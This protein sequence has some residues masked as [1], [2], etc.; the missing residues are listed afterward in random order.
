ML[1]PAE[2]GCIFTSSLGAFRRIIAYL[3]FA[4][5]ATG[6]F[7]FYFFFTF[8]TVSEEKDTVST[9]N[10]KATTPPQ[11]VCS[12]SCSHAPL[13][14]E[15][16]LTDCN[17]E[18]HALTSTGVYIKKRAKRKKEGLK[19]GWLDGPLA[20]IIPLALSCMLSSSLMTGVKMCAL[21]WLNPSQTTLIIDVTHVRGNY[22]FQDSGN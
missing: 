9:I 5:Q 4:F 13:L 2:D 18:E 3:N 16:F 19:W 1:A 14:R 21:A 8:S 6:F 7:Y 10:P 11:W 20:T 12:C 22:C 15:S 17:A